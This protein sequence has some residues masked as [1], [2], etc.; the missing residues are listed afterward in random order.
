MSK[1]GKLNKLVE[2]LTG[3]ERAEQSPTDGGEKDE[4]IEESEDEDIEGTVE[5]EC[6][7]ETEKA[8]MMLGTAMLERVG[9]PEGVNPI[10]V[11]MTLLK[12]MDE[13]NDKEK[14]SPNSGRLP[15]PMRSG[16]GEV[17]DIDYESMSSSDF[18][19]LKK[20]LKKASMDGRKVRLN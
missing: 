8:A 16:L 14:V 12:R 9:V 11:V 1:N 18:Q 15:K 17:P 10:A 13:D 5:S 20:Q 2:K 6:M 4:V 3:S 19:K 7:N